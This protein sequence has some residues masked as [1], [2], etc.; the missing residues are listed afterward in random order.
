MQF[1]QQCLD[2]VQ[3]QNEQYSRLGGSSKNF[4]LVAPPDERDNS[5]DVINE[6]IFG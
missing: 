6:N 4:S 1:L 5:Q 3:H 2:E